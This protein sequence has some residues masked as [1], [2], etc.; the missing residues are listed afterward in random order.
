MNPDGGTK[1]GDEQESGP[2]DK[3]ADKQR[4][5]RA[6]R[7]NSGEQERKTLRGGGNRDQRERE[8]SNRST[9]ARCDDSRAADADQGEDDDRRDLREGPRGPRDPRSDRNRK[10]RD[11]HDSARVGRRCGRTDR[12]RDQD[13]RP[14][15]EPRLAG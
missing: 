3:R 2:G 9:A 15:S 10:P 8:R 14:D 4:R 5:K 12:D 6:S 13:Q 1:S 11:E 7:D